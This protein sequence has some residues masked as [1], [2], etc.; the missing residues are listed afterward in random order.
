MNPETTA[1][2]ESVIQTLM[3]LDDGA[4]EVF[5]ELVDLYLT[6]A[7]GRLQ[8]MRKAAEE[9]NADQMRRA[10]HTLKGSS[11]NLGAVRVAAVC[12]DIES[13]A[14]EQEVAGTGDLIANAEAELG[15]ARE[16]LIA[17]LDRA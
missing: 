6:D 2:D 5:E 8:E 11:R 7:P 10:A 15:K 4:G 14:V 17:Q 12:A 13:R 3:E 9:D 16:G 1:I